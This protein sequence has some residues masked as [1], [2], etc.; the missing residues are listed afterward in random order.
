MHLVIHELQYADDVRFK[1]AYDAISDERTPATS[2]RCHL[3]AD[4]VAHK[5]P[6]VPADN[7]STCIQM[8]IMI[9]QF[10]NSFC[11]VPDSAGRVTSLTVGTVVAGA[12]A[13]AAP[14]RAV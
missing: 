13:A 5:R 11:S 3:G 12:T 7:Q 2:V 6:L 10:S 1:R 9:L 8:R 4:D 14:S